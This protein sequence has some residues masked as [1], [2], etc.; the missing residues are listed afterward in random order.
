MMI[1]IINFEIVGKIKPV[2]CVIWVKKTDEQKKKQKKRKRK[3]ENSF[4]FI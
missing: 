1:I 3:K 4:H 2:F